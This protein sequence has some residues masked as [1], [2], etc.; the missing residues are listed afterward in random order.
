MNFVE[1]FMS[2]VADFTIQDSQL[3]KTDQ[4]DLFLTQMDPDIYFRMKGTI[5]KTAKNLLVPK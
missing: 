3:N 2:N 4:I 5:R 1:Q